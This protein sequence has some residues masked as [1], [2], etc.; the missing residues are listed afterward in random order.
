MSPQYNQSRH[1]VKNSNTHTSTIVCSYFAHTARSPDATRRGGAS[2]PNSAF[3]KS[4]E[5]CEIALP[6]SFLH[7]TYIHRLVLSLSLLVITIARM[8]SW[9][10]RRMVR[11]I[12]F[13]GQ[14]NFLLGLSFFGSFTNIGRFFSTGC[15]SFFLISWLLFSLFSNV[16]NL[17]TFIVSEAKVLNI[18]G[19]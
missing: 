12:F 11:L 4:R 1:S 17:Q 13:F 3:S 18:N 7:H 5:C 14:L 19:A 10:W 15:M 8:M 2:Q 9:Y 16:I 6:L